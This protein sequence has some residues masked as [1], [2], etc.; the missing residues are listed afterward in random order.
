MICKSIKKI[1]FSIFYDGRCSYIK[2]GGKNPCDITIV[3][4]EHTLCKKNLNKKL[5]KIYEYEKICYKILRNVSKIYICL[6]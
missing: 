1:S 5:K 4:F 3:N 6:I 2:Y